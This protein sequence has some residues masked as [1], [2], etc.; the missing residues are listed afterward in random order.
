MNG[1]IFI[2][3]IFFLERDKMEQTHIKI[4]EVLK[5]QGYLTDTQLGEALELQKVNKNKRLGE[6]LLDNEYI[7]EEQLM[8][9]ISKRLDI[10]IIDF[11]RIKIDLK[12]VALIPKSIAFKYQIIAANFDGGR[13]ILVVND[14]LD[15]YAIEDVKSL[16]NMPTEIKIGKKAEILKALNKYYAELDSQKAASVANKSMD[17]RIGDVAINLEVTEDFGPIVNLINSIIIK[18]F[19]DGASD[20][21]IAPFEKS[22]LIRYRIDGLLIDSMALDVK[23]IHN[24][25]A[26]IKIMA[27][28]DIAESRIPQD[29]HFKIKIDD[30]EINIRVSTMPTVF[31]ETIVMRFLTQMVKIDYANSFGMNEFNF[32]KISR[33]LRKPHGIILITGPTGSGKTTTLYMLIESLIK[34]PINICTIED[35]VEK[36]LEKVN[37]VQVNP[38]AGLTFESGLRSMLRQDPD[39]ILVG[40]IRDGKTAEIAVTAAVTGHL[41]F[42]TLHTNDAISTITRLLDLDIQNYM[43]SNSVVG[44]VAQRLI[45]KICPHCKEGYSPDENELELV[46]GAKILYK[47]KGCHNCD[48]TGYKGRI[49]VHEILEVDSIIRGMISKKEPIENI[50]DYASKEGRIVYIRDSVKEMVLEGVTSIDELIEHISILF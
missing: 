15:F 40:E 28:L 33:V 41:V 16:I 14:P 45:K 2:N 25:S 46:P 32:N 22:I 26:R 4:G 17:N 43:I 50:Y 31:G 11:I 24:L 9:A 21:H 35:P 19:N 5:N 42:S 12:A 39:V 29:G 7:T 34:K 37:Q 36:N 8:V 47:G 38:K 30:K 1:D 49:A 13:V 27:G 6:I 20:I 44:I 23:L 3:L 10:E 48:F 18:G